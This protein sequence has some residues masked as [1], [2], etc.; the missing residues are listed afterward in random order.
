MP[1]EQQDLLVQLELL[2]L[3]ELKVLPVLRVLLDQELILLFLMRVYY[4]LL[5]LL[6][7]TL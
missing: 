4:K 6:D 5:V 7:L 3:P 2:V 1:L